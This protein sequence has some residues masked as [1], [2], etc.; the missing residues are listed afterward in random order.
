MRVKDVKRAGGKGEDEH[1]IRP[2]TTS[3]YSLL[4]CADD[5]NKRI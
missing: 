2:I 1:P 3:L 5:F 4:A